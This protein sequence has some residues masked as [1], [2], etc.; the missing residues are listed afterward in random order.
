MAIRSLYWKLSL[1][2][3]LA[4]FTTAGL[5]AIFIRITSADRLMQFVIDQQRTKLTQVLAEYYQAQG[6][7]QGI[8]QRWREIEQQT[9]PDEW[10]R[11]PGEGEGG[12]PFP[13]QALERRGLFSL[14]DGEGRVLVSGMPALPPGSLVDEDV[15]KGGSPIIVDGKTVGY[16]LSPSRLTGFRPEEDRFLRRVNQAL[17]IGGGGALMIALVIG[18]ALARMLTRPIKDLTSAARRMAEGELEQQVVVRS[19]D[20]IGELAQAFN[21]MSQQI[22][23][24]NQLRRQMTADIAHDLRT[25]LTVIAGYIESMRDGVL[26]P[27]PQRLDLIYQEIERLQKMVSDLRMLS[28]ADAGELNLYPRPIQ[29]LA[30][31]GRAASLFQHHAEQAGITLRVE[32]GGETGQIRVDEDRM[33]QVMDNLISNALRYTPAGGQVTLRAVREGRQVILQ[34]ADTGSGIPPEEIPH[35]FERFH[36]LDASRH[37]ESG[38]SGLGLAIVKALVEAQGGRV[39]AESAVGK[40]TTVSLAFEAVEEAG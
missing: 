3:L 4:A 35:I 20:E 36:R 6:N 1:A 21:R 11:P 32:E 29:P 17:V 38:G 9:L 39:W 34:V 23:R 33:M 19:Q 2:I 37:S 12:E 40:G 31:L 25:P 27:T 30:L 5:F 18:I 8:D 16:L 24:A 14:A 28:Q 26:Q 7:W 15:L 22:A 10:Q 13:P